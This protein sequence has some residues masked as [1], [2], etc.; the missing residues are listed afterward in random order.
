MI[1]FLQLRSVFRV[2]CSVLGEESS[3]TG[4]NGLGGQPD[5][6]EDMSA[7]IEEFRVPCSVFWSRSILE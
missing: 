1:L 6:V 4:I 2:P 3:A 7:L 5:I